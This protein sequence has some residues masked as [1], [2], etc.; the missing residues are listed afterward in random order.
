MFSIGTKVEWE[1][2]NGLK[3]GTIVGAPDEY[4]R[5]LVQSSNG[6]S[7]GNQD[8]RRFLPEWLREVE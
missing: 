3:Y 4:G 2:I 1:T 6:W 8:P 5:Y 7:G